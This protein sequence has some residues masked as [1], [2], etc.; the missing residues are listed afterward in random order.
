MTDIRFAITTLKCDGEHLERMRRIF[1]PAH[2]EVVNHDDHRGLSRALEYTDVAVIRTHLDQRFIDAPRLRWVHIDRAGLELSAR[3]EIFERG[4]LV[5]GSAGR[6]APAIAEHALL[7]MLAL[8][9]QLPRFQDAQRRRRWGINKQ[10]EL[11]ALVGKTVGILGTGHTGSALAMRAQACGMRVLG[12]RRRQGDLPS[13]FDRV[14]CCESGDTLEPLLNESDF[15]VVALPL[16]D[17]THQLIGDREM[18]RMRPGSYVV[19]VG[20]GA[21][22]DEAALVTNL[23]TG[24]LAGAG[25]DTFTV[26]P[27]PYN[28]PLWSMPNVILTPHVTPRVPDRMAR[29]LDILEENL[30]RYREGR[31]LIN[32]LRP[33]DRYTGPAQRVKMT[34]RGRRS[35][36]RWMRALSRIFR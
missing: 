18:K 16:N 30:R 6:S 36:Y 11:R 8:C 13:G 33:E 9:C 2:L 12:Y 15:V 35:A 27:L 4:L 31:M 22:I 28:S 1:L 17:Q 3:P 34:A 19:N 29:T 25:L 20:R 23:K 5:S 7:F 21:V 32:Q 14:F 26:E 24:H 10:Q